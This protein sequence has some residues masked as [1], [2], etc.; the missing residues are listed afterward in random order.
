MSVR[1]LSAFCLAIGTMSG[2]GRI[3]QTLGERV[4]RTHFTR[5]KGP[6][7]IIVIIQRWFCVV[8]MDLR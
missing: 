7:P 6:I 5:A 4:G 1:P 3:V 2:Y 8:E